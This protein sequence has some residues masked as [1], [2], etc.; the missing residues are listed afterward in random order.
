MPQ[1]P[2][3]QLKASVR[4]HEWPLALVRPSV[5]L[6][7]GMGLWGKPC[8]F[9]RRLRASLYVTPKRIPALLIYRAE[10]FAGRQNEASH[11][12]GY[13]VLHTFWNV[14]SGDEQCVSLANVAKNADL[15]R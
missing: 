15:R 6:M 12:H 13:T 10:S 7:V 2:P 14:E 5:D 3:I 9:G 11:F 4:A 8:H 1:Y